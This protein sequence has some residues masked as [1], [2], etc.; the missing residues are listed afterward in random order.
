MRSI[1]VVCLVCLAGGIVTAQPIPAPPRAEYATFDD[2][3]YASDA[4][5]QAAWEG[6]WGTAPVSVVTLDGRKVLRMPCNLAGTKIDRATW[7]K[8]VN[9]NLTSCQGIQFRLFCKDTSPVSHFSLYFQSGD[10][11]YSSSFAP[12][13]GT[14]WNTITIDKAGTRQEGKPAGWGQISTIRLS[15]WRG[16]D[17]ST[18]L[19][20]C[21]FGLWGQLGAD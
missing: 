12:T 11:W 13:T 21:D 7:D 16:G 4:A 6:L 9:L 15:A 1:T 17:V 18:E 20:V 8:K 10:G 3:Q 5:A 2:G 14:A 19:Y